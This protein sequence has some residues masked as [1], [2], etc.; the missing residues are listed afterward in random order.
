M[1]CARGHADDAGLNVPLP[2]RPGG[3]I[4]AHATGPR[5]PHLFARTAAGLGQRFSHYRAAIRSHRG[6]GRTHL[7][8]HVRPGLE[9]NPAVEVRDLRFA[10]PG[11]DSAALESITFSVEPD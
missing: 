4:P 1:A 3:G 10:Y 5:Q 7:P 8:G 2:A 11:R 9:M 6:A